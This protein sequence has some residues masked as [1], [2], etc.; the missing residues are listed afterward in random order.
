MIKTVILAGSIALVATVTVQAEPIFLLRHLVPT[1][2]I[3]SRFWV[4]NNTRQTMGL[5]VQPPAPS[6]MPTPTPG[7]VGM[8]LSGLAILITVKVFGDVFVTK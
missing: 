4:F 8:G 3:E 5:P 7:A 2:D 1:L 6:P